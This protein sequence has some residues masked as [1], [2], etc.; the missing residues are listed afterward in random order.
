MNILTNST[1]TALWHDVVVKAEETCAVVLKEELE[2]YLVFLLMRYTNKPEIVKQVIALDFLEGIN[3]SHAKQLMALQDVGDK[4]L[5]FAGLYPNIA[6]T[7][8][9]R[10]SYF[11]NMGQAAY[12]RISKKSNDLYASLSTQFVN[13]MDILQS[14][15]QYTQNYPDLLPIQAYE[16]W[17]DTGSRR[18]LTILQQYT[19]Y[20]QAIP[21][22]NLPTSKKS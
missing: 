7:R 1:S 18:A 5:L 16:L 3:S 4:C 19:Q 12:V 8:L 2:S 17:N 9:V 13:L 11:V 15:R 14:I 20:S 22:I 21:M 6:D 10:I